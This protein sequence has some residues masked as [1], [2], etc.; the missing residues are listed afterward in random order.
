MMIRR[1]FDDRGNRVFIATGVAAY[2]SAFAVGSWQIDSPRAVLDNNPSR[3]ADALNKA[4]SLAREG[5]A[6]VRRSVAALRASPMESRPLTEAVA[7][8]PRSAARLAYAQTFR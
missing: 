8:R 5:L 7:A 1:V 6:D 3:A 4:Q 2:A